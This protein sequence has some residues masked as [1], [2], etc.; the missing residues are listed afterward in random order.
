MVEV[1]IA[2]PPRLMYNLLIMQPVSYTLGRA[3][4]ASAR[5]R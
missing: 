2:E 5:K 4:P 3:G 1:P